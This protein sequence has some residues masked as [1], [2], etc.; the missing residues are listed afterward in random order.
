MEKFNP[1]NYITKDSPPV[2]LGTGGDDMGNPLKNS[3]VMYEKYIEQGARAHLYTYSLGIHGPI[4]KS[5]D[6]ATITW[7]VNQLSANPVP[8]FSAPLRPQP[9]PEECQKTFK[10]AW[11]TPDPILANRKLKPKS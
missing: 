4:G 6:D 1:L 10:S 3:V 7:V 11:C 2:F 9:G 8:E 5:I